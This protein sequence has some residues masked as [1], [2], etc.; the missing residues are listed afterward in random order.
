MNNIPFTA[1]THQERDNRLNSWQLHL[2]NTLL[3]GTLTLTT[4]VIM[5]IVITAIYTRRNQL[6]TVHLGIFLALALITFLWRHEYN[7]RAGV[8]IALIYVVGVIDIANAGIWSNGLLF[9]F[10]FVIITAILFN[11]PASIGALVLSMATVAAV[12][13]FVLSQD[14]QFPL[15]SDYGNSAFF[16]WLR[17]LMVFGLLSG[18]VAIAVRQ[19]V[20]YNVNYYRQTE[21]EKERL[22]LAER[23]RRRL[24]DALRQASLAL[25][26]TLNRDALLDH[27]LEHVGN[28]VPYDAGNIMM[29]EN[30]RAT[31][32]RTRGYRQFGVQVEQAILNFSRPLN[33]V[34]NLKQ[35]Q[36]SGRPHLVSDITSDSNWLKVLPIPCLLSWIGAPIATQKAITT[37]FSL[38]KIEAGYYQEKHLEP[39]GIFATHASLAMENARLFDAEARRRQEAET[40]Y[41]ATIAVNSTLELSEVLDNILTQLEQVL[42]YDSAC[43]FL[44]QDNT[45]R[46]V[47]VYGFKNP[48]EVIHQT[49]PATDALTHQMLQTHHP[50]LLENACEHPDFKRFGGTDNV[51]GWLGVPLLDRQ[52]VIGILTLDSH[53]SGNYTP[54]HLPLV[55]AFA[56]QATVALS[57]AHLLREARESHRLSDMLR[58]TIA[59]LVGSRNEDE[60]LQG[61]LDYLGK[62]VPY[63]SASI[64]LVEDN[65]KTLRMKAARGIPAN[66]PAW[67][68]EFPIGNEGKNFNIV[69]NKMPIIMSNVQEDPRWITIEG[70]SYIK[71]WMGIPLVQGDTVVGVLTLDH[72]EANFFTPQHLAL[73]QSFAQH[74]A[75]ALENARLFNEAKKYAADLEDIVSERTFELKTLYSLAQA[76]GQ[77]NHFED[78]IKQVLIHLGKVIPLDAAACLLQVDG[79]T[80]FYLSSH[81]KLTPEQEQLFLYNL[82]QLTDTPYNQRSVSA[83]PA[84]IYLQN[85][86]DEAPPV[87]QFTANTAIIAGGKR[88]GDLLIASHTTQFSDEHAKL[89]YTMADQVAETIGRLQLLVAAEY[90]RLENL[91]A[92]LPNGVVLLNREQRI[93]LA[94]LAARVLMPALTQAGIGDKLSSL[95][96]YPVEDILAHADTEIPFSLSL[97]DLKGFQFEVDVNLVTAGPESG[98]WILVIRDVTERE[99]LQK[100]I[101]QQERVAAVGE[102]AAGIAHDFNNILT[103]IIGFAELVLLDESISP[104]VRDD[105]QRIT[106]QGNRAAHLVR[107][108]LD[109][110][111]QTIS[112]KIHLDLVVLVQET[113]KLLKRTLPENIHISFSPPPGRALMAQVDLTQIQQVLTNLAVNARDAMPNGGQLT[114]AVTSQ[115]AF[116]EKK[117]GTKP[118]TPTD[119]NVIEVSDT[120]IGIPQETQSKIF[121]PFF[122]TKEVGKGTGLG[123]AQAYGIMKQHQGHIKVSSTPEQGTTFSLYFPAL[124]EEEKDKENL[125]L[126]FATTNVPTGQQE[127]ILLV[128]DDVTVLEI[129]SSLLENLNYR[130]ISAKNG[131]KALKLFKQHRDDLALVLTDLTMPKMGGAELIN[132]IRQIKPDIKIIAMTGYPR[133]QADKELLSQNVVAWLQ[134]PLNL[135]KLAKTLHKSLQQ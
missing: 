128:E 39:L 38:D 20:Q 50:I 119:W 81:F 7:F 75:I 60:V 101:R 72:H 89:L 52:E 118:L 116:F 12:G 76:L 2:L 61:I 106:T 57:K 8:L 17:A 51:K 29:I 74:A 26:A 43:V 100:Q 46:S 79:T 98:G 127:L 78:A 9:F 117:T 54:A 70:D 47:A 34:P 33:E 28:I 85:P 99:Y 1:P 56:S 58:E 48:A 25:N 45:M 97:G 67:H 132:A 11:L 110:S 16:A 121:E 120:G 113:I 3:L 15:E 133:F 32:I 114:F 87:L 30:N 44:L 4:P 71:C 92:Y 68:I 27:L 22:L 129:G 135:E 18:I 24:A 69:H 66:S 108:I 41:R 77:A 134:K 125:I 107:Q 35:V 126:D 102:L 64:M 40:L 83:S 19:L 123:L 37:I 124:P 88:L 55:Q 94:N 91:I 93:V 131:A 90:E 13:G 84:V 82:Q 104:Q 109:F 112:E 21:Q 96:G 130:V 73:A 80:H 5:Y 62:V 10:G 53:I 115:S 63:D 6:L 23:E 36:D 95:G 103:A 49:Y 111:R 86:T 42:P 105:V 122:T 65:S 59:T 14:H 31:V